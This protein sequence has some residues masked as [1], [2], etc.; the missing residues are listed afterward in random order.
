[1]ART[2][3]SPIAFVLRDPSSKASTPI[4]GLVRFNNDRLKIATGFKVKTIALE[5]AHKPG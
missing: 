1:M 5:R 3:N 2:A 4:V